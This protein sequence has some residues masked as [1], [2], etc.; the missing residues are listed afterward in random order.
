MVIREPLLKR[1]F[2]PNVLAAAGCITEPRCMLKGPPGCS[3][4]VSVASYPS[5]PSVQ[6]MG[7]GPGGFNI[8]GEVRGATWP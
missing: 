1:G 7:V 5:W 4:Q 8:A 6:N 3:E 2:C